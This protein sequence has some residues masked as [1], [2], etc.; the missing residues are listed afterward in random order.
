[1]AGQYS[2][3]DL[4]NMSRQVPGLSS[5]DVEEMKKN[6]PHRPPFL[7]VD[8]LV[9]V[10]ILPNNNIKGHCRLTLDK[11]AH[12]C[13]ENSCFRPSSAF[14]IMGQAY[15]LSFIC[16][17][18]LSSS[19]SRLPIKKETYLTQLRKAEILF[20]KP[21]YVTDGETLDIF[22]TSEKQQNHWSIFNGEVIRQ[23]D[24]S[25]FAK[26]KIIAWSTMV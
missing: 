17:D 16:A 24:N 22:I 1:M 7:W 6:L 25:L 5:R 14:E 13:D 11:K 8:D 26:A 20:D 21:F 12:Y 18:F 2:L 19:S 4:E 23:S 9:N 3:Q 10:E 15:G